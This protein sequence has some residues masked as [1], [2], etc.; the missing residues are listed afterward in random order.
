MPP[1]DRT[2]R[3]SEYSERV[4]GRKNGCIEKGES[5]I[6]DRMDSLSRYLAIGIRRIS[7]LLFTLT[8]IPPMYGTSYLSA[9]WS[10]PINISN[11][12]NCDY[13]GIAMDSEEN[14]H[15][16]WDSYSDVWYTQCINGE[17]ETRVNISNASWMCAQATIVIDTTNII[18]VAWAGYSGTSGYAEIYHSMND[19]GVWSE[20]ENISRT[21]DINNRYP[22]L[23]VDNNNVIQL[24]YEHQESPGY[25]MYQRYKDG[26]WSEPEDISQGSGKHA[27]NPCITIDYCGRPHAAWYPTLKHEIY[28]TKQI[29]D[30]WTYPINV[31]DE[32]GDSYHPRMAADKL[33]RIHLVWEGCLLPYG[34]REALY[35]C[36][37]NGIWSPLEQLNPDEW[38]T[39]P[40]LAIDY[41]DTIH[42]V[43][44]T[45]IDTQ[46]YLL[47]SKKV[48]NEWSPPDT[49]YPH[50]PYYP[51]LV[52]DSEN[53]LH[54]VYASYEI[55]YTYKQGPGHTEEIISFS[56]EP[57]SIPIIIPTYGGSFAYTLTLSNLSAQEQVVEVWIGASLPDGEEYG[58]IFGPREVILNP[59]EVLIRRIV[60]QV[61]GMAPYGAY[62]Y[63]GYVVTAG[64][65]YVLDHCHLRIIKQGD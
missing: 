26:I 14:L 61:P 27:S 8:L 33:N 59:F 34:H 25:V 5:M 21:P 22:F 40:N 35:R 51:C 54:C 20:P 37:E 41:G 16:V 62:C 56:M 44:A 15:V 4:K 12:G 42:A 47:Y 55:Y 13:P 28:Y 43:W 11:V 24:V 17:W 60:Q 39:D 38:G 7:I 46:D 9:E 65:D 57:D 32:P 19:G 63:H 45:M 6:G 48:D 49:I 10:D 31:S 29:S 58:P 50:N 64:S 1:G 52:V 23:A 53:S 36:Q 3:K 2:W 30:G 18:H